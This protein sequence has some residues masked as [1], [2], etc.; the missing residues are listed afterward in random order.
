MA[1]SRARFSAALPAAR[2]RWAQRRRFW[3]PCW[4]TSGM[5]FVSTNPRA[6]PR[7]ASTVPTQS[8]CSLTLCSMGH[9]GGL[10]LFSSQ[11]TT[12]PMTRDEL[13]DLACLGFSADLVMQ[14]SVNRYAATTLTLVFSVDCRSGE[15]M[16]TRVMGEN[17]RGYNQGWLRICECSRGM[18]VL[19]VAVVLPH[20]RLPQAG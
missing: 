20:S 8:A 1:R 17:R 13:K 12:G 4:T 6:L 2:A 15:K 9:A 18:V 10:L 11:D 5:V 7:I 19:G 16:A 14:V 3:D